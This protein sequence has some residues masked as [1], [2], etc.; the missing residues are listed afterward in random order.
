MTNF[1]SSSIIIIGAGVAGLSTGIFAQKNGYSSQIFE[2][3][4]LPGGLMTAW[5]RKGYTIDGCIHWLTGSGGHQPT[6][7]LW[8]DVGIFRSD[9]KVVHPDIFTMYETSDGTKVTWYCNIDRLEK[10]FLEIGSSGCESN[11]KP[12]F[13]CPKD[14]GFQPSSALH[15]QP[16]RICTTNPAGITPHGHCSTGHGEMGQN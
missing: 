4:T 16:D 5:K 8:R 15:C 9:T 10:H 12:V 6:M 3:H 14:A 11:S 7:R 2:M 1:H 13:F